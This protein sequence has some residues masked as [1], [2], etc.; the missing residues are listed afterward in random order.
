VLKL[1]FSSAQFQFGKNREKSV[2]AVTVDIK[3]FWGMGEEAAD[4]ENVP[5]QVSALKTH[6]VPK[7]I[8][9]RNTTSDN[10]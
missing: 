2:L 7:S 8:L 3:R 4:W 5:G 6:F 1:F 9:V 10:I